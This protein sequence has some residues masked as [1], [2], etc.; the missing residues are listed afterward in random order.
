MICGR[1]GNFCLD[2][3]TFNIPKMVL[4]IPNKEKL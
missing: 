3:P 4:L 2:A 1:V